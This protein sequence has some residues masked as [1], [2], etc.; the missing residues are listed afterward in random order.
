MW[1][2]ENNKRTRLKTIFE[3]DFDINNIKKNSKRKRKLTRKRPQRT[4]NSAFFGV[5]AIDLCVCFSYFTVQCTC[6]L[7]HIEHFYLFFF[8]IFFVSFHFVL[9]CAVTLF[10]YPLATNCCSVKSGTVFVFFFKFDNNYKN[11]MNFWN[12]VNLKVF[13][14]LNPV[15]VYNPNMIIT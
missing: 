12:F 10:C 11:R 4:R 1:I 9:F 5:C 6:V 13:Q 2:E 7:R 8:F 3:F 15:F 14:H